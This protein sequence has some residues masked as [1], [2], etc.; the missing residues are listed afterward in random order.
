M[1]P[2]TEG[3]LVSLF[4]SGGVIISAGLAATA[5]IFSARANGNAK[6]ARTQVENNHTTNLREESDERHVENSKKLDQVL[7]VLDNH[8]YDIRR[9]WRRLAQH[10]DDIGDLERTKSTNRKRSQ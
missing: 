4:Q 2:I 8:T 9:I 5:A 10:E 1:L 7:E 3:I 6:A